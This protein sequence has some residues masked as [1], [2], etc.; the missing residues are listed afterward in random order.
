[1]I[2]GGGLI[3][4]GLVKQFEYNYNVKFIEY[5]FEWVKYFFVN[6]D[7]I[8]VFSGDVFDFELFS[9]ENI[10]QVDVFIVVINDD[11]VNIMLVMLVKCMGVQ[12]VMVFI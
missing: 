10:E 7:K 6:L 5:S 9:E 8:I 3:G 2:V 12:K 4:V 11:E 1:M